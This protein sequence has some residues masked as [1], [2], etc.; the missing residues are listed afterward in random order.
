MKYAGNIGFWQSDTET[1]PGVYGPSIVEKKYTGDVLKNSRRF[2][3]RDGFQNG[4]LFFTNRISVLSDLYLQNNISTIKYIEWKGSK[5][6]VTSV[7]INYPRVVLE[8]GG[9]YNG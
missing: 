1:S 6:N 9:P 5:W 2:K 7:E 4:E 3:D 8:I